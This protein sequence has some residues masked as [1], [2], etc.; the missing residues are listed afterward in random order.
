MNH[1][2]EQIPQLRN[3]EDQTKETAAKIQE[4]H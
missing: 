4:H 1:P 2:N 3:A